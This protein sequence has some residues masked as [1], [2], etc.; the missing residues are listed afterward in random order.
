MINAA[1]T[2]MPQRRRLAEL[3]IERRINR[4]LVICNVRKS[5][6]ALQSNC[7]HIRTA[8]TGRGCRQSF[9]NRLQ[10]ET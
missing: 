6:I 8:K 2:L 4:E 7:T 1:G 5:I 10:I 3:A 9:E